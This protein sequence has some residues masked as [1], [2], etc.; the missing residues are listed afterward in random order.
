MRRPI[1][2]PSSQLGQ[3]QST[4]VQETHSL[5]MNLNDRSMSHVVEKEDDAG[6]I[7]QV[8]GG[9]GNSTAEDAQ[10][11][12]I[13]F[14]GE[15]RAMQLALKYAPMDKETWERNQQSEDY[16][17]ESQVFDYDILRQAP[18]FGMKVYSESIYRGELLEGKRHGLGVMQYRKAR[19]YEG[20]WLNDARN[21]RGM[22]RYSNG[23]R[24]EG[25]F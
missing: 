19:V 4:L 17:M 13:A 20:Q 8:S 22:E 15:Q 1:A 6:Q 2:T 24:Y 12:Q 18:N 21:G 23:N 25:E 9:F 5:P 7:Q 10:A 16:L 11:M 14:G 3:E